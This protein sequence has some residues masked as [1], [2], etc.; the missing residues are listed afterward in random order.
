MKPR[1]ALTAALV[2][3]LASTAWSDP[4]VN[5]DDLLKPAWKQV[6]EPAPTEPSKGPGVMWSF[7][8]SPPLPSEWPMTPKSALVRWVYAAGMDLQLHDGERVAAPWARLDETD[9]AQKLT[10]LST[11]LELIGTQGVK[12]ITREEADVVTSVF[13]AGGALRAGDLAKVKPGWCAWL[14]YNGVIAAKLKPRHQAFFTAL[15]CDA[16]AP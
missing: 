7:R 4:P 14:R 8:V 15:A 9:G 16:K 13:Q 1:P 5:F 11:A 10:T 2:V 6:K 12:P 3:S